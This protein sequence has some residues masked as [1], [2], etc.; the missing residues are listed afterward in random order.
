VL[1]LIKTRTGNILAN[2]QMDLVAKTRK[3]EETASRLRVSKIQAI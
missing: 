2:F 3:S 1:K